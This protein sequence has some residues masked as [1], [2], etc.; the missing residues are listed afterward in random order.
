MLSNRPAANVVHF[1]RFKIKGMLP[2]GR[3]ASDSN[4]KAPFMQEFEKF[5]AL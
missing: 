3:P 1:I 4:K 5:I 2:A